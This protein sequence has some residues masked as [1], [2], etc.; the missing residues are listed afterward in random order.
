MSAARVFIFSVLVLL[1]SACVR[2]ANNSA[3]VHAIKDVFAAWDAAWTAGDADTLA[4][5]YTD[6]AVAIS[7][8]RSPTKGRDQLRAHSRS[9]FEQFRDKNRTTVE[10]IRVSGNLAAAWGTQET[11]SAPK[12]GGASTRD[13]T[14]WVTAFERQRSGAWKIIWE[15]YTP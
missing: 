1:S 15:I 9:Y 10:D 6:D 8:G 2:R 12:A 11:E 7:P 13:T 3:D 4:S 5:F 14:K